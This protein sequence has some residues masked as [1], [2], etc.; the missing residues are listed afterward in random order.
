MMVEKKNVFQSVKST[1]L[2][3]SKDISVETIVEQAVKFPGIRVN[4]S[5]FLKKELIKYYPEKT[6][7]LAIANNPAYAGVDKEC[8]NTI[9]K[10]VINYEAN[11]V[12]AVSF[13]AGLPGGVAMAATVPADIVQYFGF[14]IR[15]MQKLA[16]LYGFADFELDEED[17]KTFKM[18][19]SSL[20][21]SSK[22][23][24]LVKKK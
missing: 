19:T 13:A 21:I 16:Y 18:M 3:K 8:I 9:A 10:Q 15:T 6:V 12:S 7:K 20:F 2:E 1:I 4:R 17:K 5:R 24:R 23:K 22:P 11:K 14:M